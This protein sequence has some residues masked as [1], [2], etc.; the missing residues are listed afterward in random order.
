MTLMTQARL[1]AYAA[2][3]SQMTRVLDARHKERTLALVESQRDAAKRLYRR[4][5]RA[6]GLHARKETQAEADADLPRPLAWLVR[7]LKRRLAD[8]FE[9]LSANHLTPTEWRNAVKRVLAE[10]H[11]AAIMAGLGTEVVPQKAWQGVVDEINTQVEFLNNFK[12]EIQ[13]ADE[14]K[15]GWEARARS[16]AESIKKPY[17]TGRT[18][19]LPLPAMPGE[20]SQCEQGCNCQWEVKPVSV[21]QGDYDAFW[22]LERGSKHCATCLERA[23]QWQPLRI[24]GGVLQ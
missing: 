9:E 12:V 20:G 18:K 7:E 10:H 8:L 24:R 3:V 11:L 19:L 16:Y 6:L 5:R 22:R 23:A 2:F 17:W 4:M 15:P 13:A 14:F 1:D 21:E